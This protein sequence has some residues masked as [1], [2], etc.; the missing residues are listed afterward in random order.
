[1]LQTETFRPVSDA[2]TSRRI[3]W[4]LKRL[5]VPE[6][7][8]QGLRG[9]GVVIGHIDTQVEDT[10]P[11]FGDRVEVRD[12]AST[13]RGTSSLLAEI[14]GHGLH[15]A[16]LL[17]GQEVDGWQFGVA[18]EARLL[19][20][21]ISSPEWRLAEV[22][23]AL[24]SLRDSGIR[25]LS[26]PLGIEGYNPV[27]FR[28]LQL[29][30]DEGVLPVCPIGNPGSLRF[31]APAIYPNVLSVGAIDRRG[32]VAPFSGS[33]PAASDER[34]RK[35][36]I[37]APGVSIT[38]AGPE[39]ERSRHSQN[40]TSQAS[41]LIAGVAALL[42]Q[43][44]PDASPDDVENAICASCQPV[45]GSG[46]HRS[47]FGIVDA[48][49]SLELLLDNTTGHIQQRQRV[50]LPGRHIDPELKAELIGGNPTA[51]VEC[52]VVAR[53]SAANEHDLQRGRVGRIVD[54]LTGHSR[55]DKFTT[56]YFPDAD[57]AVLRGSRQMLSQL[58]TSP[59]V[60]VLSP[61]RIPG[62]VST[63]AQ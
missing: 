58:L 38:S 5:H 9:Q 10:H 22:L 41:A 42:F 51:E 59:D 23:R 28:M 45:D 8:E 33:F 7:W 17:C 30:R 55:T 14:A 48:H 62:F 49:R 15:T 56:E 50:R 16:G 37:L 39:P 31:H 44:K 3:C 36:E 21:A 54:S 63:H 24:E 61:N 53:C 4:P 52:I 6:V 34:C 25:V 35:P 2:S 46:C 18:P 26:I 1:M 20:C 40:G 60:A 13:T 19:S 32:D 43:A 29:L 12:F 47:Q 27:F 11:A 57:T